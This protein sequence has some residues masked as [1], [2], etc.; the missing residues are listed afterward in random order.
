METEWKIVATEW[1]A[2]IP[3][4]QPRARSRKGMVGVY[5]PGNAKVWK[6]RV[7]AAFGEAPR[8]PAGPTRVDID[9]YYPRPKKFSGPIQQL[10]RMAY[11]EIPEGRVDYIKT[12][13]LDNAYKAPLDAFQESPGG[14]LYS[15][16]ADDRFVCQGEIRQFYCAVG[17]HSGA[18]ISVFVRVPVEVEGRE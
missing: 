9:F 13:D 10:L 15:Y 14:A 11:G 3:V 4:A 17:G 12:P 8:P 18:R 5:D 2:G 7:K 1:V 6:S 16:L